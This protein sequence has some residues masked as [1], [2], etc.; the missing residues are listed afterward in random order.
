MLTISKATSLQYK[1]CVK[2]QNDTHYVI[3]LL[4]FQM[5]RHAHDTDRIYVSYETDSSHDLA[6]RPADID[7]SAH[8]RSVEN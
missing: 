6:W 2:T 8:H 1:H 4:V 3:W 7:T 5:I